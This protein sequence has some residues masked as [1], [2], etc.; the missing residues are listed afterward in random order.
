MDWQG[1]FY[2]KESGDCG[3]CR[4]GIVALSETTSSTSGHH[5][6]K[7]NSVV[8]SSNEVEVTYEEQE[9]WC[10]RETDGG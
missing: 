8:V 2:R 3:C 6:W 7:D 9:G 4:D 5:I 10:V 1:Y